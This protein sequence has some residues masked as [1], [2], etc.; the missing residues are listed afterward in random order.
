LF[1]KAFEPKAFEPTKLLD[2]L[3][4]TSVG[5]NFHINYMTEYF[6]LSSPTVMHHLNSSWH[7]FA[8][9]EIETGTMK[10]HS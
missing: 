1:P 9:F 5:P 8:R 6:E 10:K 4:E 3:L 2:L 7:S